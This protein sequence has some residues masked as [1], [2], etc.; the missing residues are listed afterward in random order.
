MKNTLPWL[1]PQRTQQL[2]DALSQRILIIDGAMGTMLQS[3]KL[4][5]TGYRGERFAMAA[6]RTRCTNITVPAAT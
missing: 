6:T 3:Y 5:E 2:L 4:D 1:N